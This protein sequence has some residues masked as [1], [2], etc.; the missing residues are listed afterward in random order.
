MNDLPQSNKRKNLCF[1]D[2]DI[3]SLYSL[4]GP[5]VS[6]EVLIRYRAPDSSLRV[7]ESICR[8]FSSRFVYLTCED[9][10]L[11]TANVQAVTRTAFLIMGTA[12]A[13]RRYYPWEEA[14][15]SAGL[16][17]SKSTSRAAPI[18]TNGT[19]TPVSPS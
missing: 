13:G 3:I 11:V 2:V 5:T 12:W 9:H 7:V 4:H 8:C 1:K 14:N 6:L 18:R 19:S 15:T 16:R 10:D 17:P